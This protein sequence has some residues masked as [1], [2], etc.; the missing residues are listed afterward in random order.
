MAQE[1]AERIV[2]QLADIRKPQP[3]S[4]API[5]STYGRAEKPG[6]RIFE[7]IESSQMMRFFGPGCLP[8]VEQLI[9]KI[10]MGTKRLALRYRRYF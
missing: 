8:A 10:K 2:A 4:A 3:A 5:A 9:Q 6:A 1:I 7:G